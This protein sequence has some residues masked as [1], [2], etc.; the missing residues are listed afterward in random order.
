MLRLDYNWHFVF[1][2]YRYNRWHNKI[3]FVF[4]SFPCHMSSSSDCIFHLLHIF[5]QCYIILPLYQILSPSFLQCA[6]VL[7]CRLH[8]KNNEVKIPMGSIICKHMQTHYK[9]RDTII[10]E[11]QNDCVWLENKM[12][13][14]L[15]CLKL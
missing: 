14:L 15:W 12:V 11:F 8:C 10:L 9:V 3:C 6:T 7:S 1:F 2:L 4:C 5:V 13:V